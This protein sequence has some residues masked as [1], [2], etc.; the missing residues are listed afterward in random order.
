MF[1]TSHCSG[2]VAAIPHEGFDYFLTFKS[3]RSSTAEIPVAFTVAPIVLA[4]AALIACS[5]GVARQPM[6][7]LRT[8]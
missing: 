3:S 1:S 8:E 2:L 7:A 6:I 4:A 5:S